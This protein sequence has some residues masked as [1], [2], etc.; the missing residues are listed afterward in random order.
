[1]RFTVDRSVDSCR[2]LQGEKPNPIYEE[3]EIRAMIE[4][5]IVVIFE[6]GR[7]IYSNNVG[8]QSY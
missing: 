6:S 1:M 8:L 2:V 7:S 5:C 3:G 4:D